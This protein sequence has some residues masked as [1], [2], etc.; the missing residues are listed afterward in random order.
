MYVLYIKTDDEGYIIEYQ[1]SKTPLEGY[2]AVV[3]DIEVTQEIYASKYTP[4]ATE[5]EFD[6]SKWE[7]IKPVEPEPN[8]YELTERDLLLLELAEQDLLK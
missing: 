3:P 4:G 6:E 7:E 2:I 5:F 8:P 1:Y